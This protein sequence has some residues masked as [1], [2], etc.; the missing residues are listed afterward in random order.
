ML[1]KFAVQEFLDDREFKNVS[2]TTLEDYKLQLGKFLEFCNENEIVNVEDITQNTIK[3]YLIYYQK[4]GNN[5]TTIN[6]K[7]QRVNAL[8]NYLVEIEVID[9]NPAKKIQ[10]LKEDIRID[11]FTDYHIN[12]MLNYYRRLKNREKSFYSYRDYMIIVF[13]L[14]T[15]FRLSEMCNTKW[16]DIDFQNQT[17][18]VFG[19]NRRKDTIPITEKLTKELSAYKV[20]CEQYFK[21]ELSENVFTNQKNQPLTP[22][23]VK[24]VFKRLAKIMNFRDVRL[25]PHTFRHSFCMRCIQA[26]MPTF[27]VQKMMR[28]SSIAVTEK[29]AA[30]WGNA[31]R[32]QNDK[33]NPLNDLDI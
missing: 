4:K 22:N 30:M 2:R 14:G 26:G 3:K 27:A 8:L 31:L 12:Q 13:L 32:E 7:L 9:K 19:K 1:L 25:S 29:Y 11:V 10:R 21:K 17:I 5:A 28:H 33:Y 24:N 15:G 16:S 23:A 18:S 20:F 6:S